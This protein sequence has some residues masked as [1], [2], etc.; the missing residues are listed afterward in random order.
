MSWVLVAAASDKVP[1]YVV[2]AGPVGIAFVGDTADAD[3]PGPGNSNSDGKA[4]MLV[5]GCV[6]FAARDGPAATMA[7]IAAAIDMARRK[8]FVMGRFRSQVPR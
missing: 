1:S 3:D 7:P 8:R 4:I 2:A 5:T 6:M